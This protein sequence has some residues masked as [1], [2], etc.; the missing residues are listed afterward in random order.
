MQTSLNFHFIHHRLWKRCPDKYDAGRKTL[1]GAGPFAGPA[2]VLHVIRIQPASRRAGG[3]SMTELMVALSIA[4]I[5]FM[6]AVPSYGS[7]TQKQRINSTVNDFFA[8][9]NLTRSEAIQRGA[10][11]DLVPAGDGTDWANGWLVFIDENNDQRLQEGEK[12]IFTHGPA[13]DGMIIKSVFTDAQAQYLAYNGTGHTRTN[14]S[15]QSPQFGTLSFTLNKQ[16]RRIKINFAG[17]PRV[18]N[19]DIDIG[20]CD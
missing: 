13:P 11:V 20:K 10:R 3:F 19:P 5:L 15:S 18:C 8:A 17:R 1:P 9:I 7:M 16:I 4:I 6:M 14:T 12:V 2:T